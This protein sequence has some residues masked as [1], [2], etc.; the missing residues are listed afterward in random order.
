MVSALSTPLLVALVQTQPSFPFP[1]QREMMMQDECFL[2]HQALAPSRHR[3]R[4]N[5]RKTEV[6]FLGVKE[7]YEPEWESLYEMM[8]VER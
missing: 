7:H 4:Q 5:E 1:V 6:E 3:P 2:Q 8:A